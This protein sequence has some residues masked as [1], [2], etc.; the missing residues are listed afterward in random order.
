MPTDT[1]D[2]VIRQNSEPLKVLHMD[3]SRIGPYMRRL[4]ARFPE[5]RW[6]VSE[7]FLTVGSD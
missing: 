4:Q 7:R 5:H 3:F 6:S 2:F 1:R